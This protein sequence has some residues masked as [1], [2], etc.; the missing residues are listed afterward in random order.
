MMNVIVYSETL[1]S[2]EIVDSLS[3]SHHVRIISSKKYISS[4]DY[5]NTI[6]FEPNINK[7]YAINDQLTAHDSNDNS[8]YEKYSDYLNSTNIDFFLGIEERYLYCKQIFIDCFVYAN[9][10]IFSSVMVEIQVDHFRVLDSLLNLNNLQE[11]IDKFN[12]Y[13]YFSISK[14]MN[15]TTDVKFSSR[16]NLRCALHRLRGVNIPL[17]IVQSQ[18]GRELISSNQ[19]FVKEIHFNRKKKIILMH[20]FDYVYCDLDGTLITNEGIS[21]P[22]LTFLNNMKNN[23]KNIIL[24]TRHLGDPKLTLYD[25]EIDVNLFSEI[26]H[27]TLGQKKSDYIKHKAVFI[28]NEFPERHDVFSTLKIPAFDVDVINTFV[29]YGIE[30]F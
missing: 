1:E 6:S 13:G 24:I 16:I 28:D 7:L 21:N 10:I 2:N 8:I 29:C 4:P 19:D 25:Y 26:I 12:I 11:F 23:G 30:Y 20:H 18:M 3:F 9:N 14:E 27:L 22:V 5:R 17:M 15:G